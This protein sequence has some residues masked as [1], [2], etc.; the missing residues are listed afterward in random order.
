MRAKFLMTKNVKKFVTLV[1]NLINRAEGV[2]GM[3]LVYG[4]PGLGKSK[5]ALWWSANND[6]ILITA[7]KTMSPNWLL[8]EIVNEIGET[9]LYKSSD[10]FDQ[11]VKAL[12][13]YPR[14]IIVDEVDYLISDKDTVEILRD[15]HDRTHNPIVLIGMNFA[16]KKLKRNNHLYDRLSEILHFETFTTN[17]IDMFLKELSEVKFAPKAIDY[18]H[19]TGNRFRQIV[20][21]INKAEE[22]AATNDLKEISLETVMKITRK[23]LL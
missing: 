16:D 5:V 13:K 14:V 19:Q 22:I 18:I 17:D 23:D 2:P 8:K 3:A 12:I 15:I 9:P 21:L 7:K 1:N 11:V 20:K 6:G 4:E 10:L